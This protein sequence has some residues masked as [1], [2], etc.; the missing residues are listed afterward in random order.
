M[1]IIYIDAIPNIK[2]SLTLG[3]TRIEEAIGSDASVIVAG[4]SLSVGGDISR[5]STINVPNGIVFVGGDVACGV[6]IQAQ[7]IEINGS[8]SSGVC[9]IAPNGVTVMEGKMSPAAI[10]HTTSLIEISTGDK[11]VSRRKASRPEYMFT[12]IKTNT[13][14]AQPV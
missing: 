3:D 5:F 6:K 13:A 9:L 8:I 12:G 2:G 1:S 14:A 10:A 7:H 11:V 4:G